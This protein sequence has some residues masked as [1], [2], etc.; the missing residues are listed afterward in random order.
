[1]M[2]AGPL[3]ASLTARVYDAPDADDASLDAGRHLCCTLQAAS[4]GYDSL[5]VLCDRG[6]YEALAYEFVSGSPAQQF[7][8]SERSC[9]IAEVWFGGV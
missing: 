8:V 5:V 4:G 1:M 9:I 7:W 3:A 6:E 2:R